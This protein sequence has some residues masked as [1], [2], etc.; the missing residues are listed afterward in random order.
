MSLS[1][2]SMLGIMGSLV[3]SLASLESASAQPTQVPDLSG[4]E[5]GWVH[6]RGVGF[7]PIPGSASPVTQDPGHAYTPGRGTAYRIGD[8]SNPNLKP[9]VKD[10][11]KK[12][13]DEIDA[14]KIA[15]Q[16]SSSCVPS[17]IPL[18]FSYPRPMMI[19]QTPKKVT[20]IKEGGEIR[21]I[22]LDVP[23]SANP[24]PSWLGESVGHYEGDTLL[25]DTIGQNT[26]TF[27]DVYRTPHSETLHVV[28]RWRTINGGKG[29]EVKITVDDPDAFYQPWSTIVRDQHGEEP[30]IAE[31]ICAESNENFGLFDFHTPVATRPDF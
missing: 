31:D 21:Q 5:G 20:M 25:V 17:G 24:K 8:L 9:W 27:L 2:L 14:G 19:L 4:G 16:S 7:Q 18:M 29:L 12:D 23:H 26:K 11:M 28:E 13:T 6:G 10:V 30:F 3:I 1:G 22:Y 15:F